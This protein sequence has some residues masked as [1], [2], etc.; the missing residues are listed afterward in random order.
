MCDIGTMWDRPTH[1]TVPFRIGTDM[2][3]KE[4]TPLQDAIRAQ[5]AV[6]N[7]LAD[8]HSQALIDM[9]RAGELL[10]RAHGELNTL[11]AQQQADR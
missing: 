4:L 8:S 3:Q 9:H 6:V 1:S 5:Q 10:A 11:L 2:A 7:Q